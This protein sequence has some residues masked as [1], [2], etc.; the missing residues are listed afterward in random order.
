MENVTFNATYS[1]E[2][3]HLRIYASERFDDE[4]RE[5]FK[6]M[7]FR[8]APLQKYWYKQRWT[9]PALDFCLKLAGE[10]MP[11]QTTLIERAEAKVE[12][13]DNLAVKRGQESNTFADAADRLS[14]PFKNGQPILIGH[15]SEKRAR[16]DQERMHNLMRKSVEAHKAVDY[17]QYRA[18]GVEHHANRKSAP[19]V[20]MRRIKGLLKDLREK[21][22]TVNHANVCI[23]LWKKVNAETDPDKFEKLVKHYIG[24]QLRTGEAAPWGM[25]SDLQDG[26]LTHKE[27]AAKALKN[28]ENILAS[29]HY[30]RWIAHILNRLGYERS[31]LGPVERFDGDLTAVILQA[32][33][34][35]QGTDKPKATQT[36]TGW[37]VE[38]FV[39][40]PAHLAEGTELELD[41]DG[42]RD[43]MQ[44]TGYEVPASKAKPAPILNFKAE[45]I[46]SK[47]YGKINSYPQKEMTKAEYRGCIRVS[48]CGTFRFRVATGE[49]WKSISVFLT[50]SK[51]H[52]RPDSDAIDRVFKEHWE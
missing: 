43:L 19:G 30:R 22:H 16:K 6:E 37:K 11:E 47:M 8:W 44:G 7:G 3:N 42:W 14:E 48:S 35:E 51:V 45:H 41:A 46:N 21:Q 32:F 33:V 13:L 20:R 24:A 9:P 1:P 4:L 29:P 5:Q 18:A 12:R 50:D 27:A 15:H 17:W 39:D 23:T 25:W 52:P 26:K 49:K 10:V 2:D 40:L 38:S 34:R 36:A 31:E 28:A